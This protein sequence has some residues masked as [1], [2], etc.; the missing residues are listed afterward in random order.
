VDE[1]RIHAGKTDL[2]F[3]KKFIQKQAIQ[4]PSQFIQ[5]QIIPNLSEL[6]VAHKY[7]KL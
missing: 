2:R 6:N 4:R 5:E 3:T 7:S 1:G